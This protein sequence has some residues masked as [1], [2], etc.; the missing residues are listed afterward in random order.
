MSRFYLIRHGEPDW[1]LARARDLAG[2]LSD[3]VPLTD[4]GVEQSMAAARDPRLAEVELVLSSPYAR[5]LQTAAILCRELRKPLQVEY[6]LREREPSTQRVFYSV[7]QTRE[8]CL[9]YDRFDGT[10]PAGQ[11]KP[12]EE[13]DSVRRRVMAVLDRYRSNRFVAVVCHEK[14][15]EGLLPGV[16]APYGSVRPFDL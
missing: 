2:P 5:A 12:W 4:A 13:R 15:I 8:L 16:Q 11:P 10:Y 14:V 7:E 1:E 9:D 3:F 6:D